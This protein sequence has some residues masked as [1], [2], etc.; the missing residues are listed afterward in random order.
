MQD[1]AALLPAIRRLHEMI[2]AAVI[3]E[4]ERA[5]MD[6][7]DGR[8]NCSSRLGHKISLRLVRVDYSAKHLQVRVNIVA[9]LLHWVGEVSRDPE[10][11]H[12]VGCA[13]SKHVIS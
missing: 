7:R 10:V 2:R 4:C 1:V 13:G 12:S 3:E 9:N 5:S 11:S 8:V 6:E